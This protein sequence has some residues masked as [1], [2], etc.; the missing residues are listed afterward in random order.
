[1]PFYNHFYFIGPYL[2]SR[3][4]VKHYDPQAI[5]QLSL[6]Y[7]EGIGLGKA[8]SFKSEAFA[9]L[10]AERITDFHGFSKTKGPAGVE[11]HSLL[12]ARTDAAKAAR[13]AITSSFKPTPVYEQAE[14]DFDESVAAFNR[15]VGKVPVKYKTE[16]LISSMSDL[17]DEA[18]EAIVAQQKHEKELLGEQ[19]DQ[20]PFKEN[21]SAALQLTGDAD[22][23]LVKDNLVKDLEA[24]Q[25]KQLKDFDSES[26]KALNTLHKAC[27]KESKQLLFVA[28]L[29]KNNKEMKLIID[30]LAQAKRSK[31]P[32][33][34]TLEVGI[35]QISLAGIT[36]DD[37]ADK[38]GMSAG[39]KS[40]KSVTGSDIIYDPADKSFTLN[41]SMR[42]F[43]P[44]YYLDWRQNEKADM[45][46]I[47]QG[48]RASGFE[49]IKMSVQFEDKEVAMAKARQSFA[50]CIETG[51]PP[52]NI[53][54]D[55][56]GES[57]K[58]DDLF[59]EKPNLLKELQTK[60]AKIIEEL[61]QTRTAPA[62]AKNTAAIK[63]K[64]TTIKQEIKDEA[65]QAAAAPAAAPASGSGGPSNP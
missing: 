4:R 19:F 60:S 20:T 46:L 50:A 35:H 5:N 53:T 54:I 52:E 29:H 48:I 2:L 13:D 10:N 55:V 34:T 28:N 51:F 38:H 42:I 17:R 61:A 26:E 44:L 49:K 3:D 58:V 30:E 59:K 11:I 36:I 62:T 16:D 8:A 32:E 56:N 22:I 40:I 25:E 64:L 43:N 18:R 57:M 24:A 31:N 23:N 37:I 65:A 63:D 33:I 1:M 7:Q 14:K 6:E 45:L 41:M 47:A 9:K 27:A 12:S 15:L 21:L 39:I